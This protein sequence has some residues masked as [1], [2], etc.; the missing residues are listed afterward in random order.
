MARRRT[1]PGPDSWTRRAKA[2]GF[3]ARSVFKLED[4]DRRHGLLRTGGRVLDL[5]CHP[6]AWLRYAALAVGPNGEAVGVDRAPTAPPAGN[7]RTLTGDVFE[8]PSDLLDPEGRGFDAVLS[9]LAPD[10]TGSRVTDQARSSALAERALDLAL[11]LLRPG[12]VFVCKVFQGPDV[13]ALVGRAR[14]DFTAARLHRPP[15]VRSSS[16]E[17]YLVALG[18]RPRP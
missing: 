4:L 14:A 9:D 2:Q 3:A 16:T 8:T 13:P 11:L 18:R 5:G 17:L 1:G 15:A 6:G 12:G 7:A 10:T